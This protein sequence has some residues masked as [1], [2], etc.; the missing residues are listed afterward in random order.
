MQ[1]RQHW[2][3]IQHR[4]HIRYDIP[5]LL[6]LPA[7]M[8]QNRNPYAVFHGNMPSANG[9][10]NDFKKGVE[11]KIQP[12]GFVMLMVVLF[13]LCSHAAMGISDTPCPVTSLDGEWL[14]AV[15]PD[16][17]GQTEAWW[18]SP[19]PDAKPDRQHRVGGG[20]VFHDSSIPAAGRCSASGRWTIRPTSGSMTLPSVPTRAGSRYLFST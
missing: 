13:F 14:L 6:T 17:V 15:D 20:L 3:S 8:Y 16:N 10:R 19:R 1:V 5:N 7:H 2:G 12:N 4:Y 9:N 18:S 11:M